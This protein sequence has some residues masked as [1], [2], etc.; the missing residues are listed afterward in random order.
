M[1]TMIKGDLFKFV[2]ENGSSFERLKADG[3]VQDG[4]QEKNDET[5]TEEV[6]E[7]DALMEKAKAMGLN[8]HHKVGVEKL[9]EML[10]AKE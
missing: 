7:R 10:S 6:N 9:K 3:W 4:V 5:K 2:D 8:P 1:I